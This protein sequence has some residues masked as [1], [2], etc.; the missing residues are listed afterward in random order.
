MHEVVDL[1]NLREITEGD[2][3]LEKALFE[4]FCRC[5]ERCIDALESSFAGADNLAWKNQS[6][7]LK[8]TA[9]NLGANRLGEL[10]KKAQEGFEYPQTEKALLLE[11]IKASFEA[12]RSLLKTL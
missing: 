5:G 7:A 2:P 10:C 11:E 6:H 8:G 4:E 9:F 1:A 3:E 12:T